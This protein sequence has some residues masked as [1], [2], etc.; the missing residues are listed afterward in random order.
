MNDFLKKISALGSVRNVIFLSKRGDALFSANPDPETDQRS[1]ATD[2]HQIIEELDYPP[3]ADIV[4]ANGRYYLKRT[5]LGVLVVGMRDGS[6]LSKIKFAGKQIFDK[7]ADKNLRKKVL[8]NMLSSADDE[9][10]PCIIKELVDFADPEVAGALMALLE[11]EAGFSQNARKKLLL[12]ICRTLGYCAFPDAI[13]SLQDLLAAH[14]QGGAETLSF[15]IREAVTVSIEQLK[16]CVPAR[17]GTS[18]AVSKE[19]PSPPPVRTESIDSSAQA[20]KVKETIPRARE[21]NKLLE[22]GKTAEALTLA[23]EL[24]EKSAKNKQF[25][26]AEEL[27]DLLIQVDSMALKQIVRAAEIIEEE[28]QASISSDHLEVWKNLVEVLAPEEFSAL[29]HAMVLKKYGNGEL[30]AEQGASLATL[31]FINSGRVQLLAA[32]GSVELKLGDR[33]AGEIIG[34]ETFFDASVWTVNAKS[35]GA[36]LFLLSRSS[37]D[38]LHDAHPTLEAKLARFCSTFQASSAAL[39]TPRGDRR[40][41]QRRKLSGR[42]SFSVLDA[43]GNE[44]DSEAKGDFIDISQGGVAFS[45][46]ASRKRNALGFF[47]RRLRVDFYTGM[48][49][50]LLSRN[51][52]VRAVRDM[53]LI[54]N[55]YSVH[56]RFDEPLSSRE[57]HQVIDAAEKGEERAQ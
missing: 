39:K 9:V 12:F 8:L 3:E 32:K 57:L 56:I 55:D 30:V 43:S 54:S 25:A 13:N 45:I 37:L 5:D 18:G 36:E 27:R 20:G 21:L 16:Q 31:F 15:E 44:T 51:A 10:K 33:Q 17:P 24:I 29:Y 28:K 23:M 19:A 2:W 7:L 38:A 22:S 35:L 11:K 4:F 34:A 52:I 42:L 6:D 41:H 40:Q 50:G 47:G 49:T 1:E 53:D 46:H 48:S 14:E 26:L